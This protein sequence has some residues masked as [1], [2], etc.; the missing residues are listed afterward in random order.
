MIKHLKTVKLS[1][2]ANNATNE[3]VLIDSADLNDDIW[4]RSVR[5]FYKLNLNLTTSSSSFNQ[6]VTNQVVR[7][8]YIKLI[9]SVHEDGASSYSGDDTDHETSLQNLS[10]NWF[11]DMFTAIAA[12]QTQ[13]TPHLYLNFV[14]ITKQTLAKLKPLSLCGSN[15]LISKSNS[16]F[17]LSNS[18]NLVKIDEF[19]KSFVQSPT[20]KDNT[21]GLAIYLKFNMARGHL[22]NILF[23][24][25]MIVENATDSKV[26]YSLANIL[27]DL[28]EISEKCFRK[29]SNLLKLDLMYIDEQKDKNKPEYLFKLNKNRCIY[30]ADVGKTEL[31]IM[32][33]GDKLMTIT[34][35]VI[36]LP[37]DQATQG[38][39]SSKGLKH[40]IL[41]LI[42]NE[43]KPAPS[44]F[45][46][47]DETNF[48]DFEASNAQLKIFHFKFNDKQSKLDVQLPI[49]YKCKYIF[50]KLSS[51][52]PRELFATAQISLINIKFYGFTY[53]YENDEIF[54]SIE[55]MKL[56]VFE[57]LFEF[58]KMLEILSSDFV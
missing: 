6:I 20:F 14:Q 7:I 21:D 19:L 28:D 8:K 27:A 51:S 26:V 12:I 42:L 3:F 52:A 25:K 49:K 45:D 48:V 56:H 16:N 54:G 1:L 35:F 58:D 18:N 43:E 5:K 15:L 24:L 10:F 22:K 47:L 41:V 44:L 31:N 33:K 29:T 30:T 38:E 46:R 13:L 32:L 17:I 37:Q 57:F 4:Q 50:L 55:K 40:A 23:A 53:D 36:K 39:L 34:N 9:P 11:F 2:N